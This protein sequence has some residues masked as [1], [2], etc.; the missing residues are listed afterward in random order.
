MTKASRK[1]PAVG[2]RYSLDYVIGAGS[3]GKVWQAK[4]RVTGVSRDQDIQRLEQFSQSERRDDV[5][6]QLEK[7]VRIQATFDNQFIARVLD[8]DTACRPAY[9]V[10]ELATGGCLRQL[11]KS[12]GSSNLNSR[13]PCLLR[14]YMG[15]SAHSMGVIHQDL[16]P[17][18]S[19]SIVQVT[20]S[21]LTLAQQVS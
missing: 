1:M 19:S 10:Y 7:A 18:M 2:E 20:S 8:Q 21:S 6:V 4:H 3:L 12:E 17:E 15:Y 11:L 5:I 9:V 14:S 16:K 13:S